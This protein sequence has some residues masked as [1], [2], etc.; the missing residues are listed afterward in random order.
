MRTGLLDDVRFTHLYIQARSR[1]GY[2]PLRITLELQNRGITAEMIAEQ[3][4]ITDN[5]WLAAARH[6]WKKHFKNR[7]PVDF[8]ERAK[9]MR[10]LYYRGYTQEQ[11]ASVFA[12]E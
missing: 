1:R 2:G 3:L 6:A 5:A 8:N 7:Q 11:I 4:D 9:Q 12:S 10:F